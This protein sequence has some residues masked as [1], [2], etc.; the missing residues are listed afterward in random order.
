MAMATI[1]KELLFLHGHFVRLQDLLDEP[2]AAANARPAAAPAAARPGG[3]M[4]CETAA[5]AD[6]LA[7][8]G[9]G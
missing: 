1:W 4:S 8:G 5:R 9:C 3:A 2:P 7:C 6:V